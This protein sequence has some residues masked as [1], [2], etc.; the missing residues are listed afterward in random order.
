M[1]TTYPLFCLAF[2][3]RHNY[4]EVHPHHYMN[5]WFFF[6]ALWYS[7]ICIQYNSFTHSP[8][9]GHLSYLFNTAMNFCVY[10][11]VGTYVSFWV[12]AARLQCLDHMFASL[13]SFQTAFESGCACLTCPPVT[14]E[15]TSVW[16]WRIGRCWCHT[17]H[18][19]SVVKPRG[20]GSILK[21]D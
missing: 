9:D 20:F 12:G 7:I 15:G 8:V 11:F 3:M 10:I 21:S 14:C 18:C 19:F 5:Y 2:L 4:F 1:C 16:A 6:I 13:R 17:C